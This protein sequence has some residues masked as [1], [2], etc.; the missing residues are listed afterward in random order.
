MN[1]KFPKVAVMRLSALPIT[2]VVGTTML[3]SMA[4]AVDMTQFHMAIM[5]II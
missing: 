5:L 1:T 3:I 2:H 4:R